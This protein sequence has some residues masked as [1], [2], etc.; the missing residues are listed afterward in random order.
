MAVIAL[1]ALALIMA[2][3]DNARAL[4]V[5]HGVVIAGLALLGGSTLAFQAGWLGPISWMILSG[6]GLYMAYTPFN[7]MLFD[8]MIAVSGRIGT[9][10][11]LIYVA[12]A[13][14]YLGSCALL[15]LRNFGLTQLNWMQVF[16]ASAYGTSALG[17]ALVGASAL[18]FL[19]RARL[20]RMSP[21]RQSLAAHSLAAGPELGAGRERRQRAEES[22]V[23]SEASRRARVH[24]LPDLPLAERDHDAIRLMEIEA[25]R[26]PRQTHELE[27]PARPAFL[28]LDQRLVR[29]LQQV[30]GGKH[31]AP[32]IGDAPVFAVVMGEVVEIVG[33][34]MQVREIVKVDRQA[35]VDRVALADG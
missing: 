3:R 6:A 1:A 31:G 20:M 34:G 25:L 24:L 18:F 5:I 14:G 15:I 21:A 9:A 10:G 12:D 2:V 4:M 23:V 26:I 19:R 30:R 13:S 16:T 17:M 33:V 29:N 35:G 7:A 32:V 8:R 28:V 11:F 27:H 22:L